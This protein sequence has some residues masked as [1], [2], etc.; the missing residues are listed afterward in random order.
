MINRAIYFLP[1]FNGN[2]QVG[3]YYGNLRIIQ[4]ESAI[5]MLLF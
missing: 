5:E 3:T 1:E 2:K 4:K